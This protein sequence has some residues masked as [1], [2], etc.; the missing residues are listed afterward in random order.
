MIINDKQFY[1]DC[2]EY[3]SSSWRNQVDGKVHLGQGVRAQV[4]QPSKTNPQ[5]PLCSVMFMA[6][7]VDFKNVF[8]EVLNILTVCSE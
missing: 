3:E 6:Q 2:Y 4:S 1:L 7:N 5:A 8:I